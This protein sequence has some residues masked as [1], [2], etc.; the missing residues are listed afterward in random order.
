M[1]TKS[2]KILVKIMQLKTKNILILGAG[3][4]GI[5]V[6]DIIQQ[7]A[8]KNLII[9]GFLD[10]DSKLHGKSVFGYP[11]LGGAQ[12]IDNYHDDAIIIAVGNNQIRKNI[13]KR[14]QTSN[15]QFFR[16]I[17][18]GAVISPS[19]QIG[20]GVMVCAGVVVN[21]EVRIGNHVI[22]NTSCSVDH[23]NIIDDFAHIAPGVHLGGEVKVCEG[24]LVGLGSSV[25]PQV[26]IGE[27]AKI[28][29]GSV[30]RKD[31]PPYTVVAGNP[32]R[33]I[34]SVKG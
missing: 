24:V 16:A 15:L 14:W 22:L 18:P 32:A 34:R 29:I 25:M 13:I 20:Q 2:K 27:W 19:A 17:H 4:H 6:A 26:T 3:G 5:V 10:D 33:V 23:H 21:P 1:H 11:V 9:R 28:G 31:V 12:L 30:V 8:E 7:R